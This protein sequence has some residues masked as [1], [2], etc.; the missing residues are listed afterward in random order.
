MKIKL[1]EMYTSKGAALATVIMLMFTTLVSVPAPSA[2]SLFPRPKAAPDAPQG[3]P[4]ANPNPTKAASQPPSVI[5]V[6]DHFKAGTLSGWNVFSDSESTTKI[7]PSSGKDSKYSLH[8]SYSIGASGRGGVEKIYASPQKWDSYKQL[9]FNFYGNKTGNSIRVEILDNSAQGSTIDTAERYEVVFIDDFQGWR[10]IT[11][12]WSEFSRRNDWQPE[13][14]Q[15]NG[16]NLTNVWGL[17][18][19]PVEGEGWFKVERIHLE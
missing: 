14:A 4:K 3:K 10:T 8:F 6:I 17:N 15:N 19:A 16:L 13:G 5:Q 12:P 9:T 7:E 1:L 2:F 18:F 11:L